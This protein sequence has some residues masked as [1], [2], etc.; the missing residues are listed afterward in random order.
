M[1][2]T[3]ADTTPGDMRPGKLMHLVADKLKVRGFDVHLPTWENECRISIERWG[4]HWDLTVDDFG[5]VELDFIPWASGKADPK[6]A[7]DI[8]TFMLTGKDQDHLCQGAENNAQGMSFKG[9]AGNELRAKGFNVDL[10]VYE[11][12]SRFEVLTEILVTNPA[13]HPNA[14][15][16]IGDDGGITWECDYPYEVTAL[17]DTPEYL[18][19]PANPGEIAE[20]IVTIVARAIS[21]SAGAPGGDR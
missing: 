12:D 3:A 6:L 11:D 7:V 8:A 17:T 19:M 14:S 20:S 15:I 1:T 16:R 4:G 9:I 5:L 10:E 13:I 21:L 18:A 2:T